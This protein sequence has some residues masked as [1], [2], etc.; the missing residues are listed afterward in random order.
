MRDKGIIQIPLASSSKKL[1]QVK[2]YFRGSNDKGNCLMYRPT[3]L[4]MIIHCKGMV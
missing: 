4:S 1:E 2:A 3:L